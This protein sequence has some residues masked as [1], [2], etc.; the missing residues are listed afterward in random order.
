MQTFINLQ[1]RRRT[2]ALWLKKS[3]IWTVKAKIVPPMLNV[4]GF[5]SS[6]YFNRNLQNLIYE[7]ANL[8]KHLKKSQTLMSD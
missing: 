1:L 5:C 7:F 3:L 6:L 8:Y 2:A 4:F